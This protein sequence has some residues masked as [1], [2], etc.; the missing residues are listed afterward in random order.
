[1]SHQTT[2]PQETIAILTSG[3]NCP[4]LNDAI[5]GAMQ[6]AQEAGYKVLGVSNGYEGLL[7]PDGLHQIV[8]PPQNLRRRAGSI[9]GLSRVNPA[10]PGNEALFKKNCDT[11][12]ETIRKHAVRFLI[13]I[14]GDDTLRATGRL[15]EAGIL[16]A[17]GVPKTI[18][19]DVSATD[20]TFGFETAVKVGME[21]AAGM[22]IEAELYRRVAIVE[23]MGRNAGWIALEVGDRSAADVVLIPEA[24]VSTEDIVA[25]VTRTMEAKGNALI[26]VSEGFQM[27]GKLTCS[28]GTVDPHGHEK[29]GGVRLALESRLR[30][31]GLKTTSMAVSYAHRFA[32]PTEEDA[33]FAS[34]LGRKAVDAALQGTYGVVAVVQNGEIAATPFADVVDT[35][36]VPVELYDSVR[37]NKRR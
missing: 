25:A 35:R 6:R 4:G 36:R 13:A 33:D 11:I 32:A 1:M 34:A 20:R 15:A 28:D 37:L 3:G 21:H 30:D 26:V 19:N 2:R 18:D 10:P 14:G 8:E 17:N 16:R 29:L 31:E 7:S 24:D 23:T 22:R 5:L 12:G 9:L 27:G